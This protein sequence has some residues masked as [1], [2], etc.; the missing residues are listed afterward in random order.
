MLLVTRADLAWADALAGV[1]FTVPL[2]SLGEW[3]VHGVMYHGH[4]PGLRFMRNIHHNGHHFALFP[5]HHYVQHGP[6]EFMRFRKPLLP[7]RMADS[8]WDNFL[9]MYSQI[10]LHFVVGVP[11]ILLPAWWL[12]GS[13][14]FAVASLGALAAISWMLGYVHGVIHTPRA[15]L[16]ER[17]RW[18]QWLNHHHYL[19]HV[20][21]QSNMNFMLPLFDVLLGTQKTTMTPDEAAAHPSFEDAVAGRSTRAHRG[22]RQA[23]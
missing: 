12:T 2:C 10:G 8:R 11:L 18:F 20:D 23:A 16:I 19:H 13:A 3:L 4:L 14:A 6:Y 1:L 9:T 17:M 21:I 5:T 22:E 7:F 15:R